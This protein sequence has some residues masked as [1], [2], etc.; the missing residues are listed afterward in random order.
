MEIKGYIF[1]MNWV[2][3]DGNDNGTLSVATLI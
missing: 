1:I 3:K 2:D